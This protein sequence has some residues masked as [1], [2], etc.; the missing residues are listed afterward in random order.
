MASLSEGFSFSCCKVTYIFPIFFKGLLYFYYFCLMNEF[1]RKLGLGSRISFRID[2]KETLREAAERFGILPFFPNN[3]QGLSVEEMCAPGMLFGGN[4]DEGC[5]EWKGPV[6]RKATTAY[7]KFFHRKAGFISLQLLPD[8]L[9]FRRFA[10]PVKEGSM[11]AMLLEIIRENDSL[12]STELKHLIFGGRKRNWDDLPDFQQSLRPNV[13]SKSLESPLQRLQM[14]GRIII[15][16]F[17]YKKTKSGE[18]YG[19]GVARYSTPEI[20]FGDKLS[21]IE[22]RSPEQSLRFIVEMTAKVCG[23]SKKTLLKLLQ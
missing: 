20:V 10:F 14:G 18:R 5:W 12:S 15:S 7:G 22:G 16:D 11:D 23:V 9:N 1:L 19:W 6:I 3:V 17:E 13:K 8:F 2:S 21:E 4:Y